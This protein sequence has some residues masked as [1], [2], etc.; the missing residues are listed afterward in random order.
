MERSFSRTA[1][2]CMIPELVGG[3]FCELITSYVTG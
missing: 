2:L 1:K 3:E